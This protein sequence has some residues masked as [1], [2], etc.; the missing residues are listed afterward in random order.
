MDG[1]NVNWKFVDMLSKQLL[2][3]GNSSILNIGS[4]GLNIIHG[5]R[6]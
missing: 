5:W 2:D 1:P 6:L 3:E 4:C